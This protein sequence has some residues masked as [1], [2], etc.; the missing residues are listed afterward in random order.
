MCELD[1]PKSLTNLENIL[2][3]IVK[4]PRAIELTMKDVDKDLVG[5]V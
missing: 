1:R 3:E 5:S 4:L 2:H